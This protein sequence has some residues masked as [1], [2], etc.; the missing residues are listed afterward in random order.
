MFFV[1]RKLFYVQKLHFKEKKKSLLVI[2]IFSLYRNDPSVFPR[3]E[4]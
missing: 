4:S 3:L 2:I 1:N